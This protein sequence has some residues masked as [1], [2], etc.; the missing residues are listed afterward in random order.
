MFQNVIAGVDGY[1]G[2]RDAVALAKALGTA[3]LT[4]LGAYP[5]DTIRTRSSMTGYEELQREDTQRALEAVRL[6]ADV[7]AELV[8]APDNSPAHA[9]HEAAERI[10]ADLLVVGSAHHGPLGRALLGD[11]GRA[12]LHGAPCPVAVAPKRF[13]GGPPRR[14][15]VGFDGTPEAQA[16]LDVAA[17]LTAEDGG[18]LTVYVVWEDPPMPV[19]AAAG[20]AAYLGQ[21]T[22]EAREAAEKLLA[23]TL[24]RLPGRTDGHVLH[25][26]PDIQ[27]E[28]MAD[29]HDLI[30]VGSRGWGPVRR[31]ALGSTSDRLLHHTPAA[32][33]VVPRPAPA[34]GAAESPDGAAA[35]A[36]AR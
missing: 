10:G 12:L 7:D 11:V 16:A 31:I 24:A 29:Q 33:L 32:I 17:R 19:A 14:V 1:D 3:R 23:D 15:A 13:R 18:A 9:L 8:A 2:G 34:P 5:S 30:V 22:S 6:E 25:G 28:K 20:S 36:A 27:L 4:L 35:T 21:A 26:R